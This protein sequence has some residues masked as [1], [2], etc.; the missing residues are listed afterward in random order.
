MTSHYIRNINAFL[1]LFMGH[2]L[3]DILLA[4]CYCQVVRSFMCA[5]LVDFPHVR[6]VIFWACC[7]QLPTHATTVS[8]DCCLVFYTNPVNLVSCYFYNMLELD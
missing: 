4:C 6:D 2:P 7:T 5:I 8:V 1:D 3:L